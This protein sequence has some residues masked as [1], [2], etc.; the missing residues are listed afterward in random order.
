MQVLLDQAYGKIMILVK[1]LNEK[2]KLLKEDEELQNK[3]NQELKIMK[4][5][6]K[7]N[8]TEIEILKTKATENFISKQKEQEEY[9]TA[10]TELRETVR[11]MERRSEATS[12]ASEITLTS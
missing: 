4:E 1:E 11:Q 10:I 12:Q 3:T 5:K 7:E 8:E 6:N 9:K 2:Q